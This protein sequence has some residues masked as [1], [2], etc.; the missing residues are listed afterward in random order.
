MNC[1]WCG[2]SFNEKKSDGICPS[3]GGL[4]SVSYEKQK[5]KKEKEFDELQ[6]LAKLAREQAE[7]RQKMKSQPKKKKGNPFASLVFLIFFFAVMLNFE[8]IMGIFETNDVSY[9]T[10]T[11][12]VKSPTENEFGIPSRFASYTEVVAEFDENGVVIPMSD[13]DYVVLIIP[14]GAKHIPERAFYDEYIM[15]ISFPESLE[16]IGDYAFYSCYGLEHAV[17]NEGLKTIGDHAFSGYDQDDDSI[18]F[19]ELPSTLEEVGDFAFS[20]WEEDSLTEQVTFSGWKIGEVPSNVKLGFASFDFSD[21]SMNDAQD[22]MIIFNDILVKYVGTSKNVTI[23]EGIRVIDAFAFYE[24]EAVESVVMSNTV[25]RIGD[26]AF[27]KNDNLTT[28]VFSQNLKE[29]GNSAFYECESLQSAQLPEGLTTMGA[30]IFVG[31][32][33]LHDLHIPSTLNDITGDSFT[34]CAWYYDNYI[35]GQKQWIIGDSNLV[36]YVVDYGEKIVYLPQVK[37]IAADFVIIIQKEEP[38]EIIVPDGVEEIGRGAFVFSGQDDVI[39]D[40]PDSVTN[41]EGPLKTGF[42]SNTMEIDIRCNVG[43]YAY[44]YALEYGYNIIP[45]V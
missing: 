26:M 15:A 6:Q 44:D 9:S 8:D 14:E 21:L 7:A 4:H 1:D 33:S 39:I 38:D 24:N 37:R 41:I 28:V 20:D 18:N 11:E 2:R 42:S 19:G 16:S 40:L 25:E 29:I 43:T 22:G 13:L 35:G 45:K 17:L 12:I 27:F 30:D 23:P 3:C 34:Y 36:H 10:E 31:C 32:E 5:S